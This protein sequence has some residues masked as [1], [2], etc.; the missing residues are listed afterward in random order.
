[1]HQY[2]RAICP[3]CLSSFPAGGVWNVHDVHK[4]H[5]TEGSDRAWT[6]GASGFA[7]L[8]FRFAGEKHSD[9]DGDGQGSN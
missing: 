5:R 4:V 9:E 1:M 8:T 6:F 2:A 7:R 3:L